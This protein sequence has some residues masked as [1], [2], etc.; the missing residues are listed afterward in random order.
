MLAQETKDILARCR[1]TRSVLCLA[2]ADHDQGGD[3]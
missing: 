1:T 3:A 2:Q